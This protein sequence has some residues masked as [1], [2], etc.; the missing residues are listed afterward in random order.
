[1]TPRVQVPQL[2]PCAAQS[3]ERT[4]DKSL[5]TQT[6]IRGL[7]R[8]RTGISRKSHELRTTIALLRATAAHCALVVAWTC[9]PSSHSLK[10]LTAACSG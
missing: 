3:S 10:V 1:M 5:Y 2:P 9:A 6:W 7:A 8:L 4:P